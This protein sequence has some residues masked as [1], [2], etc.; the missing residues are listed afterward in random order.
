MNAARV[1]DDVDWIAGRIATL[2]QQV[3][4]LRYEL[5]T[6]IR[7]FD[8]CGGWQRDGATSCASWLEVHA[9]LGA[10]KAREHVR[11]ARA[12]DVFPAIDA[13]LASGEVSYS[14]VKAITRVA[15]A[16]NEAYL[17]DAARANTAAELASKCSK[18]RCEQV[19]L[20]IR[21]A[22]DTDR[23]WVSRTDTEDRR[24]LPAVI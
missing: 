4:N 11:V 23:R 22:F 16:D 17:V 12:L 14:K 10:C 3:G 8:E 20:G 21:A 24:F 18:I 19:D 13:A 2:W 9:G 1:H 7:A 15:T 5:L 6:Y